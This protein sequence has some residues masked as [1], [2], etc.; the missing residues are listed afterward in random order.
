MPVSGIEVF[1]QTSNRW[2]SLPTSLPNGIAFSTAQA[3][4]SQVFILGGESVAQNA[5][6]MGV[7]PFETLRDVFLLDINQSSMKRGLSMTEP[8]ASATS[9]SM[10]ST[11]YVFGGQG[12][13][14]SQ[15]RLMSCEK[16]DTLRSPMNWE[17]IAP[18]RTGRGNAGAAVLMGKSWSW[19]ASLDITSS[20]LWKCTTPPP[21]PGRW[22][23][24]SRRPGMAWEWLSLKELSMWLGGKRAQGCYDR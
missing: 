20:P 15:V 23:P 14:L 1:D 13:P 3:L 6:E 17:R 19:E 16:L 5:Q 9:V 7:V 22:A 24:A 11:I 2:S 10:G 21:T 12:S 18:M 4:G 8:R